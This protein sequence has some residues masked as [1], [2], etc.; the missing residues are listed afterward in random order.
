MVSEHYFI[1]EDS[2]TEKSTTGIVLFSQEQ[3]SFKYVTFFTFVFFP[4]FFVMFAMK[5]FPSPALSF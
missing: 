2:R 5:V 4:G 3:M 1:L